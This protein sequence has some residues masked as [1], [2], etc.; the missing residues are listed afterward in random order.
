MHDFEVQRIY[1]DSIAEPQFKKGLNRRHITTCRAI[2]GLDLPHESRV[3][4]IGCGLGFVT[5]LVAKL[6]HVTEVT[7]LDL[8]PES[9][10]FAKLRLSD[11]PNILFRLSNTSDIVETE[12]YNLVIL[13]HV[14][15]HIPVSHH[16]LLLARVERALARGGYVLITMCDPDY[17]EY[18]RSTNPNILHPV[19]QSLRVWDLC[20]LLGHLNL[21]I[22][23]W[24][25]Y[26]S[27]MSPFDSQRLVLQ[28]RPSTRIFG[29][30]G[31]SLWSKI[32]R[33]IRAPR[34]HNKVA[35]P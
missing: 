16:A 13:A 29:Y 31:R 8:S 14:L 25:R 19:H 18:I 30:G 32:V 6:R 35:I 23:E 33:T 17:L 11:H 34:Q 24:R 27:W 2:A 22:V 12:R 10:R 9:L 21:E 4:D 28:K 3:L 7:A 5:G 20:A 26:A 15:E 1:Y